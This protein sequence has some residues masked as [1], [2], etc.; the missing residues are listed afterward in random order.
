M[1]LVTDRTRNA[2][3]TL[4]C[5]LEWN[6]RYYD[7]MADKYLSRYRALRLATLVAVPVLLA[8]VYFAA[9]V[10]AQ[11]SAVALGAV[12]LGALLMGLTVWDAFFGYG[13]DA[14][15]LRATAHLCDDLKVETEELW[16]SIETYRITP[17]GAD[18]GLHFI[19]RRLELAT[20]RVTLRTDAGVDWRAA[21]DAEKDLM[22]RFGRKARFRVELRTTAPRE[23][24]PIPDAW[25]DGKPPGGHL[26]LGALRN[27][28]DR[29]RGYEMSKNLKSVGL[30]STP[31]W[32]GWDDYHTG[33]DFQPQPERDI[34]RYQ[35]GW[36][37]AA[38]NSRGKGGY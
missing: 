10:A 11:Y 32:R 19:R 30:A 29:E 8:V 21:V 13:Q 2:V 18:A 5:D 20:R 36:L 37:A 12:A 26:P 27:R 1:E 33:R 16:L 9:A 4:L 15:T 31:F 14:V 38:Y 28:E 22:S 25:A 35:A 24:G 6:W 3:W 17:E 7:A 34:G 23:A